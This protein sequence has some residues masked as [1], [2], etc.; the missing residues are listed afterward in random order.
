MQAGVFLSQA[1]TLHQVPL[2]K[3][4]N[5]IKV[6]CNKNMLLNVQGTFKEMT[7]LL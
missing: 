2:F 3:K 6:L 5:K 7:Y 1:L 4:Y